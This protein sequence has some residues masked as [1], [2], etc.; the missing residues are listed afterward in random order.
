[1]S[2]IGHT[3]R[4]DWWTSGDVELEQLCSG[5]IA[6]ARHDRPVVNHAAA[7]VP[8][9]I[10]AIGPLVRRRASL[11]QAEG[12]AEA[13]PFVEAVVA[14]GRLVADLARDLDL[15]TLADS[16]KVRRQQRRARLRR[17]EMELGRE[18]VVSIAAGVEAEQRV[19]VREGLYAIERLDALFRRE[20]REGDRFTYLLPHDIWLPTGV[21]EIGQCRLPLIA[22][23]GSAP[24]VS[25][26]STTATPT[27]GDR[28]L[29]SVEGR[30]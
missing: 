1:M 26:R 16:S 29:A 19:Q 13:A 7:L 5:L 15:R 28:A 18:R 20:H 25:M 24:D 10:M 9:E 22:K 21:A 3:T 4:P 23:S 27:E 14:E 30:A 8:T 2:T 12:I 6:R 11:L 17:E